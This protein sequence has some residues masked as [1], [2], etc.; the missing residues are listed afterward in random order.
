MK[1][2]KVSFY[3]AKRYFFS[4]PER[5][6]LIGNIGFIKIL[7]I[8]SV[9]AVFA[10][11]ASLVVVLSVFNG[12]EGLTKSLFRQSNPEL[13]V[14]AKKGKTFEFDDNFRQ[15]LLKLPHL[16]A[17]TEVIEDNALLRYG[18]A[19]M[20]VT[21][22]GVSDNFLEQYQLDSAIIE[23]EAVLKED[24]K[25]FALIGVGIQYQMGG[26]QL[27]NWTRALQFWYPKNQKSVQLNPAKAFYK[28]TIMPKGVFSI[29][30]QLDMTT[31]IVP[32]EF[33][34]KLIKYEHQR[35]A[36]EIKVDSDANI[37]TLQQLLKE[38]LGAQFNVET[39]EEQQATVLRAVKVERLF[40]FIAFMFVL[41]IA[42]FNIFACL[43]ILTI[44]KKRDIAILKSIGATNAIIRN[45]FLFEGALIGVTGVILGLFIAFLVCF[46][47]QEFGLV[48]MGVES[49]IVPAYPV[50]MEWMDF[51]LTGSAM[52][53]IT[54]AAS[55]IPAINASKTAI[56]RYV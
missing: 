17:L 2:Q 20:V 34:Q 42:S 52:V 33:M 37:L 55:L 7:S 14:S 30:Q 28:R 26:I 29:E 50:V 12:L 16:A 21:L 1:P 54:F 15:R 13:K 23:G 40:V 49:A 43:V 9:I 56:N 24:D 6:K 8:F 53:I 36:L 11:T 46:L 39:S 45:I 41:V 47:Q 32:I 22:K 27:S 4:N 19:Q 18:D 10:G 38:E 25:L 5:N 31:V 35:T 51:A 48:T 44:E 3:I